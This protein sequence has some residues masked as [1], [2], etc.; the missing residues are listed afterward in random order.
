MRNFRVLLF[1]LVL[2]ALSVLIITCAP[3]QA[4]AAPAAPQAA[5]TAAAATSAPSANVANSST[6]VLG[7]IGNPPSFDPV[8]ATEIHNN[9]AAINMYN[10]LVQVKQGTN[11]LEMDL[12][13]SM[14][15]S[16]D[17]LEY[18]F[19]L[20][21]GVKFHDGTELTA[22]DVKYTVDRMLA[23]KKGVYRNLAPLVGADVV[24][25]YTVTLKLD[26]PFPALP[27]ALTRLYILN[28]KLVQANEEAGDMGEKWLVDHDAGSGPYM[29]TSWQRESS[30]TMDKFPDYFKGWE[31]NHADRVIWRI[32]K[33]AGALQLAIQNGELDWSRVPQPDVWLKLKDTP[34]IVTHADQRLSQ[35]YIAFNTKN[36]YLQD[37]KIRQ[38]LSLV[39]DY[40]GYAD[41]TLS[42]LA[43][44]ASGPIPPFIA[45]HDASITPAQL[46]IEQAKKL[47]SESKYPD[48]GFELDIAYQDT[49]SDEPSVVQ[50]LQA[51]ASEIG[52]QVKPVAMEWGAKVNLF[53]KEETSPAM[54]TIW[55]IPSY[56][57]PDQFLSTIGASANA[58]NGGNNFAWY[59]NPEVD[60]LLQ[61]ARSETDQTKR[62]ELYKQVQ[63]QWVQDA[64]Y[65]NIVI[66]Q[67]L[68]AS[69]E[70]LKGYAYTPAQHFSPQAYY[71]YLDGKP[72]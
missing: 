63:E 47:M 22:A 45:C 20:R 3:A 2:L 48:G 61:Q 15:P 33:E 70:W 52:I 8:G 62:C 17:G 55:V 35:F 16:A 43:Q 29:L 25:D 10:A 5:P 59:S 11:D 30:V 23:L 69:Q 28:S 37:P 65:A 6:L 60:A 31:G 64:P 46:N 7:T 39:Y 58:G 40:Q 18:T 24:D 49:T 41:K 13:E 54:G 1:V 67:A 12:A 26:A 19:K 50:I 51:G 44:V 38:A 42:G 68:S 66:G 4:P 9:A 72:N 36:E 14:E 57:D 21:E 34:G 32:I 56:S 53:S 71:M 27:Q